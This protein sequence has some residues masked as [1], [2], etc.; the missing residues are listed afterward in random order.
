MS[1]NRDTLPETEVE[2]TREAPDT[3]APAEGKGEQDQE[4]P[5]TNRDKTLL[6]HAEEAMDEHTTLDRLLARRDGDPSLGAFPMLCI[7]GPEALPLLSDLLRS[8]TDTGQ[9]YGNKAV[10]L[11]RVHRE[12]VPPANREIEEATPSGLFLEQ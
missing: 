11:P 4:G 9:Y 5:A 2:P 8:A 3:A 1:N 7:Q 6:E 12:Q 10:I